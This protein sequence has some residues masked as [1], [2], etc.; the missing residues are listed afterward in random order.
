MPESDNYIVHSGKMRRSLHQTTVIPPVS[1]R[2][3]IKISLVIIQAC[4]KETD[5]IALFDAW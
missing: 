1:K 3:I 4:L 2:H 5:L